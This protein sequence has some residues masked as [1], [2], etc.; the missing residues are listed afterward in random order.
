MECENSTRKIVS[1]N[2]L[3]VI[4]WLRLHTHSCKVVCAVLR[5]LLNVLFSRVLVERNK[6]LCI[7]DFVSFYYILRFGFS[8]TQV[9]H[10]L[11][12]FMHQLYIL[13]YIVPTIDFPKIVFVRLESLTFGINTFYEGRNSC[14]EDIRAIQVYHDC[15][16]S[17]SCCTLQNHSLRGSQNHVP[18]ATRRSHRFVSQSW[19]LS[20]DVTK[21]CP[22]DYS[23]PPETADTDATV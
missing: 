9:L 15:D 20:L 7:I 18:S 6:F 4:K 21:S 10:E 13:L 22:I 11:Y 2:V 5:F 12:I 3:W 19:A 14:A 16:K 23:P 17:A 8:S 1:P